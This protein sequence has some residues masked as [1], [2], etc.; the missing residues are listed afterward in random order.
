MAC[1]SWGK[2]VTWVLM[3]GRHEHEKGVTVFYPQGRLR[4]AI[5]IYLILHISSGASNEAGHSII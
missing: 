1:L 3:T 4:K 2:L 5:K